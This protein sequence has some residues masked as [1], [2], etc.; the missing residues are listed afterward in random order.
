MKRDIE[1]A[2]RTRCTT[3]RCTMTFLMRL[4]MLSF[5]DSIV[6]NCCLYRNDLLFSNFVQCR[7]LSYERRAWS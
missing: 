5:S 6:D 2:V 4:R 3:G 7:A 1:V